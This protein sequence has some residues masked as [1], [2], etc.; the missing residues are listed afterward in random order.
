MIEL[1]KVEN[2]A[3][4]G[5]NAKTYSYLKAICPKPTTAAAETFFFGK[6]DGTIDGT[7]FQ[8]NGARKMAGFIGT[9]MTEIA[10]PLRLY[11]R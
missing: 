7:H 4:V 11:L 8:E 10:L 5:L 2:V 9:S 6:A 1:G 3:V